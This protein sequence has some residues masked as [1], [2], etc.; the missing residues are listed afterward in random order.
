MTE[1]ADIDTDRRQLAQWMATYRDGLLKDTLPFWLRHSIDREHGGYLTA[2]DQDGRVVD[3]DKGV[4]QQARFT[5][6]LGELYNNVDGR[7]EWLELAIAGAQFLE[8][9][10]F[11]R[12]DGRMW[13]HVT[14]DGQPIRKRRYAFSESFTAIAF[15]ELARATGE[16]RFSEIARTCFDQFIE[17]QSTTAQFDGKFT[18]TRR[19][20]E[21]LI[22]NDRS[23]YRARAS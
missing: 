18:D 8:Q 13:F 6:L 1:P 2:L 7:N 17:H 4:W 5:W 16:P 11:D 22:S 14:Q 12:T 10:C 23:R 21:P 9:H 19:T 15:G 20:M 3:S